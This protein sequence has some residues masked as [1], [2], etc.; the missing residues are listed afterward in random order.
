M[1][2][3]LELP[4][5]TCLLNLWMDGTGFGIYNERREKPRQEK[6]WEYEKV[7]RLALSMC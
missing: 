1:F 2:Q 6:V 7:K 4:V 5:R 3:K